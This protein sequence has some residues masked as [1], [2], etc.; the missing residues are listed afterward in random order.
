MLT[1]KQG[2]KLSAIIDK[3]GLKIND[4]A[5]P[6]EQIGAD[7][8]MQTVTKL[9]KAEQEVY[10]LVADV[11]KISTEEAADVDIVDFIQELAG[12]SGAVNFFKSAV[13]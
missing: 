5:A 1:L 2:I 10:A 8:I 3:L 4:P 6:A 11:K 12:D 13:T 9:H 7:L